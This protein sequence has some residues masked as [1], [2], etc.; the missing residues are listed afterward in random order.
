MKH[1]YKFNNYTNLKEE[2]QRINLTSSC[3]LFL[4]CGSGLL[5]QVVALCCFPELI[6]SPAFPED[7]KQRARRILQDCGGHSVGLYAGVFQSQ[8]NCFSVS[9]SSQN[10]QKVQKHVK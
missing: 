1:S 2:Y 6:H 4:R 8:L 3:L 9:S 5:E 10:N 7:A